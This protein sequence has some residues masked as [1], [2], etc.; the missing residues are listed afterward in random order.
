VVYYLP[1]GKGR[2]FLNSNALLDEIVGGWLLS[3]TAVLSSGQPFTVFADGNT[4]QHAGSQFPNW[5]KGVSWKPKHQTTAQW[6]NPQAFTKPADGTFGNV[7]RNS[8]YGPGFQ[9]INLS[10]GKTFTL[11][12]EG[13][14]MQVRADANDVFNHTS[15]GQVGATGLRSPDA[16]GV[17]QGPTTSQITGSAISGRNVQLKLRVSF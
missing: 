12:W 6:Y 3:G 4:Y 5:N 15:W 11:P 1:F 16:S 7:R 2:Q 13:I 9:S 14:S 17:Y 8:L 10:G